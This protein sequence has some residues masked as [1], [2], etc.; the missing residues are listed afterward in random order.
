[1]SRRLIAEWGWGPISSFVSHVFRKIWK[2]VKNIEGS[3]GLRPLAG[4]GAEPRR[5]VTFSKSQT[6][7]LWMK[8]GIYDRIC[9]QL[10][11]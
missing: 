1:M 7:F 4:F 8:Q 9:V 10:F 6:A 5:V 11:Q 3:K 2:H